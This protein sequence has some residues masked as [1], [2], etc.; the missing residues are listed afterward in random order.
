MLGE[1]ERIPL[2][3]K[4]EKL[5]LQAEGVAAKL[6]FAS[7]VAVAVLTPALAQEPRTPQMVLEQTYSLHVVTAMN[8]DGCNVV[9]RTVWRPG[10][11]PTVRLQVGDT[12]IIRPVIHRVSAS[13]VVWST[14]WAWET[15]RSC[16]FLLLST[17]IDPHEPTRTW[18]SGYELGR[19]LTVNAFIDREERPVTSVAPIERVM[20]QPATLS[21]QAAL[22]P[23]RR[24]DDQ[25]PRPH[26]TARVKKPLCAAIQLADARVLDLSVRIL[27]RPQ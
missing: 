11:P 18:P 24:P 25:N 23:F 19:T 1:Q 9:G 3:R 14:T 15:R 4:R 13:L 5:Q 20:T 2:S 27:R 10:I 7:I 21:L 6:L 22:A 12:F 17:C 26:P 16:G 8:P